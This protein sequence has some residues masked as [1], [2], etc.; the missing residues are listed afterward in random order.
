MEE[1][2]IRKAMKI[3]HSFHFRC[4]AGIAPL[5]VGAGLCAA[6]L[7][8]FPGPPLNTPVSGAATTVASDG[9]NLLIGGDGYYYSLPQSLAA[10]NLYWTYLPT[11]P[12]VRI[13]PGAVGNGDPITLYGGSDG[14]NATDTVIGYSPS[15]DGTLSLASMSVAR[16][17][18]G[19]APDAG[20]NAY[21]IGG[22]DDNGQPLSTA[23]YY[24]QDSTNWSPIASLPTALYDF[25]A[26]F[27]GTSHIYAFGGRTNTTTGTETATVL[28]YSVSANTWT[29]MAPMPIAVA[30]SAAALGAD[31]KIH[32]VGGVS[33][34]VTINAVQV[35]DPAAN[36]WVISTPLPEG[37]SASAMGVDS[38]GR[39]IVMGGMDTNGN[40]V[41]DVWRSQQLGVPD[42]APIFTQYPGTNGTYQIAYTSSISASGNPQPTY[43]VVSGPAGLLVDTY[44]GAIT[45][46]PQG[47]QVGS[48]A[49]TIRATNYAGFAD[50]SFTIV[51]PYPRPTTPTNLTEVSAT[52]NS[53]TFSWEPESPAFGPVT[54]SVFIPHPYHSPRG[55]GGGVNYQLVVANLTSPSVTL[56]GLAPSSSYGYDVNATG[57]GGTSG[58]A[59]IGVQTTGPQGPPDLFVTG[60]TSTTVSLAWDSAPGPAQNAYYSPIT[61]YTIMERNM[62]V[63]PSA[64]VPTVTGITGTNGTITGLTPGRSHIWF[65]SG[66]DAAGNAS[67]LSFVYVV[68]T[69]PVPVSPRLSSGAPSAGGGFQLTASQG[70]SVLQTVLIQATTNLADP[71]AWVQIGSLLPTANP[72]TFTDT[73]AAQ[74]PTRFYRILAP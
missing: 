45:W 39:L 38:L 17:Y 27:D 33:G 20:G 47:N 2:K 34:G 3:T 72:F 67:A 68:V 53:V 10:T 46:T 21:A 74:Y 31:G 56:S 57:P 71:N 48:N 65:V 73:N 28:R 11:L 62:S 6:P 23:E 61:S 19:Y 15:G 70:G 7:T 54:Y 69:N 32:V 22:L 40:D 35:Y 12:S 25:P 44:S 26:V 18:L 4:L 59:G 24:S 29:A 30:G 49:V 5:F 37:L 52:D 60:L 9:S 13:A 1:T 64:N 16:A 43:L 66:V 14:T 41:S 63:S 8:W 58:Y 51:V 50:W 42:S 55:S 36:A